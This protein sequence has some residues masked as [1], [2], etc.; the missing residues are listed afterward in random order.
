[1]LEHLLRVLTRRQLELRCGELVK[2]VKLNFVGIVRNRTSIKYVLA[3]SFKEG[4]RCRDRTFGVV[5]ATIKRSLPGRMD[6]NS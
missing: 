3:N 6:V 2:L 5:V 1:L 4:T